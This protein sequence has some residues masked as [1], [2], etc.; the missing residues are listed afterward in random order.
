MELSTYS[1]LDNK[2]W[3]AAGRIFALTCTSAPAIYIL[4]AAIGGLSGNVNL[5][6]GVY[7]L[8]KE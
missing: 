3:G 8:N 6:L 7:M 2:K 4:K 1:W 5:G